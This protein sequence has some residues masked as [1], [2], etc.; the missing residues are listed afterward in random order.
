MSA[1]NWLSSIGRAFKAF[2]DYAAQ[3]NMDYALY[4]ALGPDWKNTY[5]Q[6]RRER[7]LGLEREEIQ[8]KQMRSRL[9]EQDAR[10]KLAV[11]EFMELSGR[12]G[13][14]YT[15]AKLGAPETATLTED[16]EIAA[17]ELGRRRKKKEAFERYET[18][19]RLRPEELS[20]EEK[21]YKRAQT[22]ER[23]AAA[24]ENLA[25][26]EAYKYKTTP[27]YLR[28]VAAAEAEFGDEE[29]PSSRKPTKV[30]SV[31]LRGA[32]LAEAR[33]LAPEIKEQVEDDE[34]R[35]DKLSDYPADIQAKAQDRAKMAFR[36]QQSWMSDEQAKGLMGDEKAPKAR[37]SAV[38]KRVVENL[39]KGIPKSQWG[40]EELAYIEELRRR[41]A[42]ARR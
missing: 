11:S 3:S 35:T 9:S 37:A 41:R 19:E 23:R 28:D 34:G 40:K 33:R 18:M 36:K 32:T 26:A 39:E 8:N 12:W 2:P 14:K 16:V 27:K 6:E 24:E 4:R 22:E 38:R 20:E 5:D 1:F 13:P 25:Q 31:M 30:D 17:G 21:D 29:E 10:T 15:P 42:L 7:E